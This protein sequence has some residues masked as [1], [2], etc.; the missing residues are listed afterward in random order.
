MPIT[1]RSDADGLI[2]IEAAREIIQALPEQSAAMSL[3]RSQTMA[4]YQKDMPVMSMF[5]VAYWRNGETNRIETTTAQWSNKTLIAEDLDCLLILP[6]NVVSDAGPEFN[7]W[8]EIKPR[9]V[10]AIGQAID[11]AVFWGTNFPT[12]WTTA[13]ITGI[14]PGALA[15]SQTVTRGTASAATGG[16]ATD[17]SN[18]MG[19]VEAEGFNVTGMFAGKAFKKF[20]RNAVDSTGQP[21][22]QIGGTIFDS[23]VYY[24]GGGNWGTAS[25]AAELVIGDYGEAVIG[26]R[27]DMTFQMLDQAA[28]FD[29]GGNLI[30][31]LPQQASKAIHLTFRMGFQV[32]NNIHQENSDYDSATRYP[33]SYIAKT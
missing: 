31:N 4:K 12:S 3:I 11:A 15:A 30:V 6:N 26:I 24:G 33:W 1:T 16:L 18:A 2:P 20:L 25:G 9:M 13:G 17:I 22:L 5:P 28:L 8:S 32:S 10:E 29:S 27:E 19:L 7:L 14:I 23:P 21:L